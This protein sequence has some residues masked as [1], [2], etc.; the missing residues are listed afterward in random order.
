MG[1]ANYKFDILLLHHRYLI[2]LLWCACVFV[3]HRIYNPKEAEVIMEFCRTLMNKKI[4][5]DSVQIKATNI[6]II[7]PYQ[8][9]VHYLRD[10]LNRK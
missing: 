3:A 7:T 8:R 1:K 9:Q 5:I 10:L 4:T 2:V 6:G